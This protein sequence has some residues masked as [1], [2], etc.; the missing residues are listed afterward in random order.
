MLIS[1]AMIRDYELFIA[2][3][4]F[5]GLDP[6][7]IKEFKNILI[8]ERNRKKAI[9]IST[10]LLDMVEE[11]CDK[12]VMINAGLII[13]YGTKLD[14]AREYGLKENMT[15]EQLYLSII[16]AQRDENEKQ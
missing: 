14:I 4:P 10:H 12:Y 3:E 8:E 15:V 11:I 1:M 2:D 13:A 9:L 6:K 16:D 7:Q 5:N